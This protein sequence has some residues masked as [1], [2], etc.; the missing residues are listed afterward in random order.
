MARVRRKRRR[1]TTP[2]NPFDPK[3]RQRAIERSLIEGDAIDGLKPPNQL[4]PMSVSG[5]NLYPLMGIQVLRDE[6]ARANYAFIHPR[7]GNYYWGYWDNTPPSW[8]DPMLLADT[9]KKD[10]AIQALL[11]KALASNKKKTVLNQLTKELSRVFEDE[12]LV[13][14]IE[15][16]D[17]VKEIVAEW[18]IIN[19]ADAKLREDDKASRKTRSKRK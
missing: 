11:K 16:F 7:Y 14:I 1:K 17:L 3:P 2:S 13:W 19:A 18:L 12:Y 5:R 9:A 10:P 4:I 8:M 6:E 15:Q